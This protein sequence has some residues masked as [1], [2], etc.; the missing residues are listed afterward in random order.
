MLLRIA[1]AQVDVGADPRRNAEAAV[2]AIEDAAGQGARLVHFCEGAL[3]GYAPHDLPSYAT[4][5]WEALRSAA[6]LVAEAARKHRC[7]VA[8]G[9][10]HPLG[11]GMLPHNAVYVLNDEG[12]LVDRYDKR[13][14]AGAATDPEGE[15]AI[16]APGDHATVFEV[17]GVRCGILICHE[18]RYPE[19]YRDYKTRGVSLLLH[20]YHAANMAPETYAQMQTQVGDALHEHNWGTTLPEITMP[21]SMVAAS[22]STHLWISC[23]NSSRPQSCWGSFFVRADG[24]ITGRLARNRPGVLLSTI[25]TDAPLYESTRPWRQRAMDGVFHSGTLVDHPRSRNRKSF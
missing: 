16:Y 3:S 11:P 6:D 8:M 18:Y 12:Q 15:L 9:S 19:L 24:V 10:A 22:A 2:K 25:D 13:F 17:D 23:A 14:C 1:T 5:D 21:A 7:W 20:S 4:Y